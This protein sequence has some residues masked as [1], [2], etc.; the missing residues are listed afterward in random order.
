VSAVN[1]AP[2]GSD[3]MQDYDAVETP[4]GVRFVRKKY[5]GDV[6]KAGRLDGKDPYAAG[7]AAALAEQAMRILTNASPNK[8]DPSDKVAVA[9][10]TMTKRSRD[11]WKKP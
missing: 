9:R 10:D 8:G 1:I 4:G 2:D 3:W 5:R 6:S 11:A 7:H